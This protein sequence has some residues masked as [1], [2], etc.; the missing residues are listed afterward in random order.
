LLSVLGEPGAL[1]LP[2]AL[3]SLFG[4]PAAVD[5]T[6]APV[7]DTG[8]PDPEPVV[9]DDTF[10]GEPNAVWA[11]GWGYVVAE[12]DEGTIVLDL[13]LPEADRYA[14]V[15]VSYTRA[16]GAEDLVEVSAGSGPDQIQYFDCYDVIENRD[17]VRLWTATS[18]DLALDATYLEERPEWLC[19]PGGANPVYETHLAITA[20]VLEDDRG[21]TATLSAFAADVRL[22]YD[23]CGG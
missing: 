7:D 1:V 12:F 22:G 21:D 20:L 15:D 3:L 8:D 6:G 10:A 4:C 19:E 16:L 9:L 17:G 18:G 13:A 23:V 2:L 11:C 5:D 14:N